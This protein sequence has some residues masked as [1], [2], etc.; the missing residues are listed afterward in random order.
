MEHLEDLLKQL[1]NEDKNLTLTYDNEFDFYIL[2]VYNLYGELVTAILGKT[3]KDTLEEYDTLGLKTTV[4]QVT[5][6]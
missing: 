1:A 6:D 5:P 4:P 2:E 3:I